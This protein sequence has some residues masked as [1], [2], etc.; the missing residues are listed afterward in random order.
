MTEM[1]AFEVDEFFLCYSFLKICFTD[2]STSVA[3]HFR[4]KRL[5][6]RRRNREPAKYLS[7]NEPCWLL[8]HVDLFFMFADIKYTLVVQNSF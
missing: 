6:L 5:E 3:L 1:K 8:K 4:I 2:N 7:V